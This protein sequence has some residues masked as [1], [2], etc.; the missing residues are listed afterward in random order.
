MLREKFK[1]VTISYP[2]MNLTWLG[3]YYHVENIANTDHLPGIPLSSMQHI[4]K[5]KK[6]LFLKNNLW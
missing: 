5:F 4:I 3:V 6:R 1:Q 2:P